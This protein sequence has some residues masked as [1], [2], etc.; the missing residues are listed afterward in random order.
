MAG[1]PGRNQIALL[2]CY[3]SVAAVAVLLFHL[4]YNGTAIGGKVEAAISFDPLANWTRHGNF[5]VEFFFLISGFAIFLMAEDSAGAFAR[6][7]CVVFAADGSFM[8]GHV[9]IRH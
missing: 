8:R 6:R 7:R 1:E 2:D 3:R 9:S 5:G 4:T